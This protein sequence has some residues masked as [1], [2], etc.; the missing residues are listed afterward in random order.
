MH[1]RRSL[2]QVGGKTKQHLFFIAIAFQVT[3]LGQSTRF[4]ASA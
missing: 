3:Q 1:G 4:I 2:Q